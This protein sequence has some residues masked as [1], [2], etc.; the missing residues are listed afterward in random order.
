VVAAEE[1]AAV[2]VPLRL[3]K[4]WNRRRKKKK[5]IWEVVWI[6]LALKKEA[7]VVVVTIKQQLGDYVVEYIAEH[8]NRTFVQ[9]DL[10]GGMTMFDGQQGLLG[11]LGRRLEYTM[12]RKIIA[13][14]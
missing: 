6:C 3:K 12:Y 8:N 9:L 11:T 2:V 14:D 5:W 13:R 1:A 7:T 4:Q 10:G